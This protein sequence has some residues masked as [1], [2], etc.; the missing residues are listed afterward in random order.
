[1]VSVCIKRYIERCLRAAPCLSIVALAALAGPHAVAQGTSSFTEMQTLGTQSTSFGYNTALGTDD[2]GFANHAANGSVTV[3]VAQYNPD[4]NFGAA[5]QSVTVS[6]TATVSQS[7][8]I[9]NTSTATT[10]TAAISDTILLFEPPTGSVAAENTEIVVDSIFTNNIGSTAIGD[11]ADETGSDT[12][13]TASTGSETIPGGSNP[14]HSIPGDTGP[15]T[16][17]TTDLLQYSGSGNVVFDVTG[18]A[19]GS[20]TSD[21]GNVSA[22]VTSTVNGTV[23]VTFGFTVPEPSSWAFMGIG[24]VGTGLFLRKRKRS[25]F[26]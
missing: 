1:M 20:V 19:N 16:W 15:A 7:W 3:S 13:Q 11:F 22:V 9:E 18:L 8:T 14:F 12:N 24:V 17:T 26:S 5:L 23:S 4:A 25:L 10:Y 21:N 6:F 2:Q